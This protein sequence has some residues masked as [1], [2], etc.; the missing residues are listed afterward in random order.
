MVL[1]TFL[2]AL[3]AAVS[4]LLWQVR[5]FMLHATLAAFVA[6]A[7]FRHFAG[8]API[9][10]SFDPLWPWHVLALSSAAGAAWL[11]HPWLTG[12]PRGVRQGGAWTALGCLHLALAMWGII[13]WR[14]ATRPKSPGLPVMASRQTQLH[15]PVAVPVPAPTTKRL[16]IP[17]GGPS[18]RSFVS[19]R[20]MAYE[21]LPEHRAAAMGGFDVRIDV[22][23][24][25]DMWDYMED[26]RILGGLTPTHVLP[27]LG[28][29]ERPV[30]FCSL[31]TSM[32]QTSD[33]NLVRLLG[34]RRVAVALAVSRAGRIE[35]IE[36]DPFDP[37]LGECLMRR[38]RSEVFP[39]ATATTRITF[40]VRR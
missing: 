10:R 20:A 25:D 4:A 8:L 31:V 15:P 12:I 37:E 21:E 35:R 34:R 38:M 14:E 19:P 17:P 32:A 2:A 40:F 9:P 26:V 1:P 18:Q 23:Q 5:G 39:R 28:R 29:A 7:M 36:T 22:W 6:C 24:G 3:V 16:V 30:R 33:G 27:M 13:A 11:V